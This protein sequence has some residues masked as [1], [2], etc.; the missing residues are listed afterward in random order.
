[1]RAMD[2][3]HAGALCTEQTVRLGCQNRGL[4]GTRRA[5]CKHGSGFP[6]PPAPPVPAEPSFFT[7]Q[8]SATTSTAACACSPCPFRRRSW[9][10]G[11]SGSC[12]RPE[13]VWM[14]VSIE[15]NRWVGRAD[16]LRQVPA[17]V[18]FISAEPLLGP[19]DELDLGGIDWLIAGGESGRR[20]RP[21]RPEWIR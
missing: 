19:L 7:P 11:A 9:Q 15:N 1:M 8:G 16:Y 21:V 17:A 18:R 12:T 14:G 3:K 4:L 13:N 5:S 20:H 6:K 2:Q 10:I